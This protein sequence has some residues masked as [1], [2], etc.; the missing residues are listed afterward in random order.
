[1]AKI[2]QIGLSELRLARRTNG[3]V[4]SDSNKSRWSSYCR[5]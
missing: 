4:E 1:M 3:E 2:G 5:S